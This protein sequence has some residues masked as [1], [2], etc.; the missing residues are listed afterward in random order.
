MTASALPRCPEQWRLLFLGFV[1]AF[2]A[3]P[4]QPARANMMINSTAL[5]MTFPFV[6]VIQEATGI[7]P[8]HSATTRTTVVVPIHGYPQGLLYR[9]ASYPHWKVLV[10]RRVILSDKISKVCGPKGFGTVGT[11]PTE[12]AAAPS[13]L[14]YEPS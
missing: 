4:S 9:D 8:A 12:L 5:F 10:E 1:A 14:I 2:G 3:T 11:G 6:R 7:L 13:P